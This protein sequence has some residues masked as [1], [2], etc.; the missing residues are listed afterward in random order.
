VQFNKE[1]AALSFFS[2]MLL[3]VIGFIGHGAFISV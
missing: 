2:M 1:N 3:S